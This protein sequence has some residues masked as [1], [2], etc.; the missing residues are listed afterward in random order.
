MVKLPEP[1]TRPGSKTE[2]RASSIDGWAVRTGF[3][4]KKVEPEL[5]AAA[6]R[7]ETDDMA[8]GGKTRGRGT[9][10]ALAG[11]EREKRAIALGLGVVMGFL[12][13]CF[14]DERMESPV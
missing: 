7:S 8:G 1:A 6:R 13:R 4:R 3:A 11:E 2:A 5:R 9:R 12:A 14:G 10:A